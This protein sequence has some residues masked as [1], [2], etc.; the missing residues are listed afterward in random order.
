[1][2]IEARVEFI[3]RSFDFPNGHIP[4]QIGIQGI[5]EFFK[6]MTPVEIE[7]RH[8]P[9]GMSAGIRTS[10]QVHSLS[11]PAKFP[12]GIFKLALRCARTRLALAPKEA[13]AVVSE[14]NLVTCH[15]RD[16]RLENWK[17]S[18]LSAL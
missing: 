14:D 17:L 5:L 7:G 16:Q 4:G 18:L 1:V 6:T 9:T 13:C 8:L 11:M 2:C 15:M 10:C 12:Q 3:R